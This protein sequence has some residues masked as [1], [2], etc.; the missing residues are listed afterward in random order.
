MSD[1]AISDI[2]YELSHGAP[3]AFL[4]DA[5]TGIIS[6]LFENA[7]VHVFQLIAVD[8]AGE[9]AVLEEHTVN[10]LVQAVAARFVYGIIG[11]GERT[12]ATNQFY[13]DPPD[14][15][16]TYYVG[17]SYRMAPLAIDPQS[18]TV[19]DGTLNDIQF[20]LSPD[21]P[22]S[23]FVSA[24]SGVIFGQFEE[25]GAYKFALVARDGG[26][27]S[28][29]VEIFD[30]KVRERRTFDLKLKDQRT[31]TSD[32]SY[33]NPDTRADG[34]FTEE[35]YR[36]APLA[37]DT[38]ATTVSAGTVGDI[39]FTLSKDAPA[40]F[41]V[42]A[43]TGVVF[44]RFDSTFLEGANSKAAR[45]SLI[46]VDKAGKTA[47]V[48]TFTFNVAKRVE[49]EVSTLDERKFTGTGYI[50]PT[51]I[52]DGRDAYWDSAGSDKLFAGTSY[53]LSPPIID[54]AETIVSDGGVADVTYALS[55]TAP[56]SFSINSG[57]GIVFGVFDAGGNYEFELIGID[58]GL[59]RAV[60]E[61]FIFKVHIRQ[62]F[63]FEYF[64]LRTCNPS[65]SELGFTDPK[66][67]WGS[68]T[69][70]KP[71][72]VGTT[73][74]I[75]PYKTN[76]PRT[77]VSAGDVEDITYRLSDGTPDTFLVSSSSGRVVCTFPAAGP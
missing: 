15:S 29:V 3:S 32:E 64:N 77:Q 22:T 20:T 70:R 6:G 16:L 76:G 54:E 25:A 23:F 69:S 28:A 53:R 44:G 58:K 36:I 73:Y 60:V 71:P 49:F 12:E 63:V 42:S 38:D 4:V 30:F 61:R 57:T 65:C 34:Y 56:E 74:S 66:L 18:T 27:Q 75:A 68:G 9:K 47:V 67:E 40:S 59:Q 2:T 62:P 11:A 26:G 37:I 35:S 19:S 7:G 51:Y 52:K 55:S 10:A 43:S 41:L 31:T 13:T 33:I 48:E 50:A 39:S 1:G 46:A 72:V 24:S 21:A 14:D 5:A 17:E 45:F 8:K